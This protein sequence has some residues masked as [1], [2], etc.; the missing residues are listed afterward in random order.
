MLVGDWRWYGVG[1]VCEKFDGCYWI[2]VNVESF[3]YDVVVI[4]GFC[5]GGNEN[6]VWN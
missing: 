1:V 6:W 2:G 5:W 4:G 3:M